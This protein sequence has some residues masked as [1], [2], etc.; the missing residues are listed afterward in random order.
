MGSSLESKTQW[1]PFQAGQV[2]AGRERAGYTFWWL[3]LTARVCC[4]GHM[5]LENR[6][7]NPW[8][9][10]CGCSDCPAPAGDELR[11]PRG[12]SA[13]QV[14]G[15]D[16][17][18]RLLLWWFKTCNQI[19]FQGVALPG[20]S[21][22]RASS[23]RIIR[24][25]MEE[26]FSPVGPENTYF[27]PLRKSEQM[28]RRRERNGERESEWCIPMPMPGTAIVLS[29]VHGRGATTWKYS[30]RSPNAY[31]SIGRDLFSW[32]K[33][34]GEQCPPKWNKCGILVWSGPVSVLLA[35][36]HFSPL[37]TLVSTPAMAHLLVTFHLVL[38]LFL[39]S[40]LSPLDR[41]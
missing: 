26:S 15:S 14:L 1:G 37:W 6:A 24:R 36:S 38:W 35:R 30:L 16:A 4:P 33:D 20:H 18:S 7:A 41:S 12:L 22:A 25:G 19:L 11:W 17:S 23:T 13:V 31:G 39:L 29:P 3:F 8:V 34:P 2:P 28:D 10:F 9:C 40:F 21:W 5:N 27:G 32:N